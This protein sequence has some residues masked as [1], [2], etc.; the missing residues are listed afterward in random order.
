MPEKQRQAKIVT[1]KFMKMVHYI[2][3]GRFNSKFIYCTKLT[4]PNKKIKDFNHHFSR[5][6]LACPV[7]T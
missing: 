5:G 2:K 3:K 4:N 7:R 6:S 1:L